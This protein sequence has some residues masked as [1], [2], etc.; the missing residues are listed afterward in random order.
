MSKCSW[1]RGGHDF[2]IVAKA[3]TEEIW[4]RTYQ[5][6]KLEGGE[7]K[8]YRP[9]VI[10]CCDKCGKMIAEDGWNAIPVSIE[11][12]KEKIRRLNGILDKE[13]FGEEQPCVKSDEKTA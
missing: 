13:L 9:T 5:G 11:Y 10:K 1:W 6:M 4:C 8:I 12:A 7:Y 2:V 3:T